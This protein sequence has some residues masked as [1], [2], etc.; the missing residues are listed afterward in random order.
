MFLESGR[1]VFP[2]KSDKQGFA[3]SIS[4]RSV[5]S[6]ALVWLGLA[7][8]FGCRDE[9]PRPEVKGLASATPVAR[10]SSPV[11][12]ASAQASAP[13]EIP[14]LASR[15]VPVRVLPDGS[16]M[17]E[18]SLQRD[19]GDEGLVWIAAADAC[20]A[21][22]MH[23][24]TS[25]QW[26][27]AC[28]ADPAIANVETWTIT[29]EK[30]SGFVVRGGSGDCKQKRVGLGVQ[31]SPF[32][33]AA[34]CSSAMVSSGRGITPAMLRAMAKN[35]LDFE[36]A[37]NQHRASALRSWFDDKVHLFTSEKTPAA[38]VEV[39][40]HEL[41]RAEDYYVVHELCDF[42]ADPGNETYTADCRKIARQAGKIGHVSTRYVFVG[43]SGKVRSIS[44]T[45]LYRPFIEP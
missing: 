40:E 6:T 45:A 43:G 24:C 12:V 3:R 35:V 16:F 27:T 4:Y 38:A 2:A 5:V 14:A 11:V 37:L 41:S 20:A 1:V 33:A 10:A 34:C 9:V 22:E 23:L 42:A 30:T 28:E 29:P 13:L 32:R 21:K 39:F 31:S 26:Q 36:R 44:D 8:G 18:F 15:R 25:S 7:F 19:A 17:G